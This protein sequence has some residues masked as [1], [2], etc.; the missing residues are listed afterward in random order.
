MQKRLKEYYNPYTL[1]VKKPMDYETL[2]E[3][4]TILYQLGYEEVDVKRFIETNLKEAVSLVPMIGSFSQYYDKLNYYYSAEGLNDVK[5]ILCEM[6]IC[7]NAE[8]IEWKELFEN[9]FKEKQ[10]VLVAKGDY[11]LAR[12]TKKS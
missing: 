9:E 2:L 6:M 7:S 11:E 3:M 5:A 12:I 1:E 8:Y 4:S 10:K